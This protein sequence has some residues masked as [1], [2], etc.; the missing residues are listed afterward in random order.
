MIRR[1]PACVLL[2][3]CV[4]ALIIGASAI[5][6]WDELEARACRAWHRIACAWMQCDEAH[7]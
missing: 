7:G 3:V 2:A 6:V 1:L 5:F 4:G